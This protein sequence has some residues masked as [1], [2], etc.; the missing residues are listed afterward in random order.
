M[1]GVVR[2]GVG[3]WSYEPWNESF[4]PP[5]WP[6]KKQLDYAV[7]K[8]TATE[9]NAT[10]Y[11]RQKPATFANWAKTAPEGFRFALKGSRYVTNRRVLAD[12]G[13]AIANFFDQGLVE[14]GDR[15]GPINWQLAGTK[16]FDAG[17][18]EGFFRLL[19]AA[20]ECLPLHH[21]IEPRHDSFDCAAFHALAE[22]Y[23]VAVARGVADDYPTI[24]CDSGGVSYLRLQQC[25]EEIACGYS[26]AELDA[27]AAE[28]K[29]RAVKGDVYVFFIGGAKV[30]APA[31]AMA[32][33]ERV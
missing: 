27:I 4:Y 18:V 21:V 24:A 15:L 31:A 6:K 19:P 7:S 20:V 29:A 1:A 14:L 16:K 12:A 23:N 9:V 28:V 22:R 3:G 11:A 25:R 2:V 32:L 13:E 30:R 26:D 8:L 33:L 10:F 17:D 5:K